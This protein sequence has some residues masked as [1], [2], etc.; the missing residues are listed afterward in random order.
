[1]QRLCPGVHSA[2]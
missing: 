2:Q 1:M